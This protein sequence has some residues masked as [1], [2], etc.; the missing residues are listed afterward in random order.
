MELALTDLRI[1][2]LGMYVASKVLLVYRLNIRNIQ[3]ISSQT[4]LCSG[5]SSCF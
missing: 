4:F 5:C 3:N 2:T 1:S